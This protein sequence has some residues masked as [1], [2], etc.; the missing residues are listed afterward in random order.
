MLSPGDREIGYGQRSSREGEPQAA[1]PSRRIPPNTVPP[2]ADPNG[3]RIERR[4]KGSS[5]KRAALAATLIL[6]KFRLLI[7]THREIFL[8]IGA[9]LL[10]LSCVWIGSIVPA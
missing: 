5:A 6:L 8:E 10:G 2:Y 7:E 4:A 9:L 1:V 3:V